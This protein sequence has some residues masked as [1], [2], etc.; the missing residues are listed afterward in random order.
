M[1]QNLTEFPWRQTFASLLLIQVPSQRAARVF[2]A[3]TIT[4]PAVQGAPRH[5]L[6]S[7]WKD[8]I[9]QDWDQASHL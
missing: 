6:G 7:V 9:Q 3:G 1:T 5:I 2:H 4:Q 8:F